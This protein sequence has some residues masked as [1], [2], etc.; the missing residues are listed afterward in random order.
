MT[1][2]QSLPNTETEFKSEHIAVSVSRLPGS[3]VKLDISV[4]PQAVEAS[5]LKAIKAVNKE[6]SLPGFRKGKAPDDI[7]VKK[8]ENSVDKEWR[9]LVINTGFNEAVRL[10]NLQPFRQQSVRCTDVKGI[11]R[12][13]GAKF[14]IEFEAG[15]V[16]P[17]I[18]MH[19]LSLP[20]MN[21]PHIS[22]ENIDQVIRNLQLHHAQW[23]DVTGR[24]VQEGDYIDMDIDNL[25]EGEA[26]ICKDT[27]FEVAEG[28]MANWMR[29]L[30]IGKHVND[31]VEGV[32]QKENMPNMDE[33]EGGEPPDFKPTRVRMII[34]AIKNPT[35]PPLDDEFAKKTGAT[36]VT[37]L[38]A[39]I[40]LDLQRRAN[41]K[42]RML[43]I[44]QLDQQLLDKYHFDIPDSLIQAEVAQR[45][46]G[47]REWM[48]RQNLVANEA[49]NMLNELERR[50]PAEVEKGCRLLFL[51][52]RFAQ[53]NN[54]QVSQDEI[55]NELTQEL[56]YGAQGGRLSDMG[57]PNA[58]RA[59]ITQGLLLRKAKDFLVNNLSKRQE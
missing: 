48:L 25:D 10:I 6:V 42:V 24:T 7:I 59:R 33:E 30:L 22:E 5:Y 29:H 53:E 16:V 9:N 37:D 23:E 46:A 44:R 4:T 36:N 3:R 19:D 2:D 54:L 13:E 21:V 55:I 57:D 43:Q 40:R 32:S 8:F 26:P 15:P 31:R 14:V 38:T 34:K 27:R 41:E 50:L 56:A 47:Q 12:T 17:L 51:L 39:K 28:I 52:L 20:P 35:L 49:Q 45:M 11:S 1:Q 58:V 18:D